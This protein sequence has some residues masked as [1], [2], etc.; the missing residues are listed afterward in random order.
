MHRKYL[1][2]FCCRG[3]GHIG[4]AGRLHAHQ[5]VLRQLEQGLAHQRAGHA[6]LR[7]NGLFGQ[8]GTGFELVCND[9]PGQC[10]TIR[11][12]AEAA[13]P[14]LTARG[15]TMLDDSRIS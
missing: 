12:V 6:K 14:G 1:A 10:L 2:R 15:V 8:F 7:G 5:A 4:T 9:S 3:A 11:C 13:S